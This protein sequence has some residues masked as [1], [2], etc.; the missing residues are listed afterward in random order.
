VTGV[1]G[2]LYA[3]SYDPI[4]SDKDYASECDL[5]EHAIR[6]YG[7]GSTKTVLDLGCG[8][9]NHAIPLARRG[10]EVVGVDRSE[11]MLAR[12]RSKA[13]EQSENL[14]LEFHRADISTTD[15]GRR[16][17]AVLM[18][19]AVLSYQVGNDEVTATLRAARR[20]LRDGGLLIC[21]AWYGPA[22]LAQ[23]PAS[24]IKVTTTERGQVMRFSTGELSIRRCTCTVHYRLWRLE[25]RI[26]TEESEEVHELRYFFPVEFEHLLECS[27][28][29]L[30]RL[31]AFPDLDTDPDES[32]WNVMAVARAAS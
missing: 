12:A 22:V 26:L 17:D 16:F 15:L 28:L 7:D 4:Y 27:G 1:F 23:R 24:R 31:G 3:E 6:T 32:S 29:E 2:P 18:M 8:T 5:I 9:G 10:Y 13:A 20:H 25:N 21:D 19:F 11:Q 30:L 14:K